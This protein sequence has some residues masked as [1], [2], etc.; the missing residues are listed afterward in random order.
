[1][2]AKPSQ[3]DRPIGSIDSNAARNI[4]RRPFG[5]IADQERAP[6]DKKIYAFLL[7]ERFI[8]DW[9][10]FAGASTNDRNAART[11]TGS[12]KSCDSMISTGMSGPPSV[13]PSK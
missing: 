4:V 12:P 5:V 9:F 1:M 8:A 13:C 10:G 6:A 2:F 3:L 11:R 7:G